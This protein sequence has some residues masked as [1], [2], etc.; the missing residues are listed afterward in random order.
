MGNIFYYADKAK[1]RFGDEFEDENTQ[2]KNEELANYSIAQDK[3]EKAI[4]EN[5]K[6]GEVFYN[7]G[8]IYYLKNQYDK[9]ADYMA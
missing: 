7:L 4:A 5:Y 8:R 1:Y 3:Y 2:E 9:A 6:S